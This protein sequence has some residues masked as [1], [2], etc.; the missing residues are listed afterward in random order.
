MS[1][2]KEQGELKRWTLAS[3]AESHEQDSTS[4]NRPR[5]CWY[6]N[7]VISDVESVE[8]EPLTMSPGTGHR[9]DSQLTL[10]TAGLLLRLQL[11]DNLSLIIF[12]LSAIAV[13]TKKAR[14]TSNEIRED[15]IVL[16][17]QR[18]TTELQLN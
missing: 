9:L 18:C 15:L 4:K 1:T 16:Q 11:H 10:A 2:G 8:I 3:T 12:T 7:V 5:A 17:H 13:A 14:P 6:R